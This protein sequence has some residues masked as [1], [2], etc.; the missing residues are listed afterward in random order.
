MAV[1]ANS[2][3]SGITIDRKWDTKLLPARYAASVLM[4]LVLNKSDMVRD[5]GETISIDIEPTLSVGTVTAATGQ[6]TPSA[7]VPTQIN[8]TVNTWVYVS[9]EITKQSDIQSFWKTDSWFPSAAAKAMAIDYDQKLAALHSSVAAGNTVGVGAPDNFSDVMARAGMLRLSDLNVPKDSLTFALP[10]VALYNG[11]Y[12]KEVLT[13]AHSSGF[14]K[15]LN[16]SGEMPSILGI[17]VRE[18]TTIA[19]STEGG[20]AVRKAMLLHKQALGIAMQLNHSYKLVDRE[21]AGFLSKAGVTN[22]LYGTAV[23]RSDH[24]IVF[25][26]LANA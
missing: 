8:I 22:S 12:A 1:L 6:F 19:S 13:A 10:P 7:P 17:P 3:L 14:K 11:W 2:D 18:A 24:F 15:N 16:V 23:V 9:I 21:S 5:S 25:N 20:I 26:V 4:P